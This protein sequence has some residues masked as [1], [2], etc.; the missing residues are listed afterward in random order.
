MRTRDASLLFI[1]GLGGS[2]TDHWQTRWQARLPGARRVEQDDWHAPTRA[3][4]VARIRQAIEASER[5]VVV[6]AHSLGVVALA[7]ALAEGAPA[8]AGAFLVAAPTASAI[9]GLEAVD[10]AFLPIPAQRLPAPTL[11]VGSRNDPY[12]RFDDT[13]ALAERWGA[14]LVDAGDSGHINADSGHGPWP[15]GL[16]AFGGFLGKL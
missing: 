10:R 15:E 13:V 3:A 7:H 16:M 11:M 12:A 6:L 9:A 4:W 5:P 14:A 2:G 8:V 1:P